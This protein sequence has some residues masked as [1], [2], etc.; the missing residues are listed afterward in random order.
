[1]CEPKV[2]KK[3]GGGLPPRG[4]IWMEWAEAGATC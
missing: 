1:M 2:D 4:W 3:K